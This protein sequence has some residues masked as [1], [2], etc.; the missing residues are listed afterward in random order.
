[1]KGTGS[2]GYQ[3]HPAEFRV[4]F[5][6]VA[7]FTV[8]AFVLWLALPGGHRAVPILERTWPPLLTGFAGLVFGK[9]A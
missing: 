4:A 8:A 9:L 2:Q 3:V 5:W 7:A 6:M 1:M